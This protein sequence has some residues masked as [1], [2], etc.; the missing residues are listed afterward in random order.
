[1]NVQVKSVLKLSTLCQLPVKGY[2]IFVKVQVEMKSMNA[3]DVIWQPLSVLPMLVELLEQQVNDAG[4]QLNTMR[5]CVGRPHVLDD[6]TVDRVLSLYEDQREFL[7]IYREQVIRWNR[8]ENTVEQ[9]AAVE[10]FSAL[11]AK[12]DLALGDVLTLAK[13]L[14]VGTIDKI[15]GMG[16]A[17]LGAAVMKGEIPFPSSLRNSEE[18]TRAKVRHEIAT[19]V[20]QRM[21]SLSHMDLDEFGILGEMHD[22]MAGFK[23]LMDTAQPG[24]FDQLTRQFPGLRRFAEVLTSVAGKIRSGQIQVPK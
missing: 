18:Q 12:V 23:Q 7:N 5:R 1:M 6:E 16:E 19:L 20:D 9:N 4:L 11:I 24:E 3:Q 17:E 13:E 15:V 8:E 2:Q 10:R 14:S 22:F 21:Q